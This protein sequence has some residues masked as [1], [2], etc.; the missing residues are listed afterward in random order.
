MMVILLERI[1]ESNK[2]SMIHSR[3]GGTNLNV[4]WMWDGDGMK[5]E[6]SE[7]AQVYSGKYKK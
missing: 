7:G 4:A 1:P 6:N 3:S 5:K 2:F